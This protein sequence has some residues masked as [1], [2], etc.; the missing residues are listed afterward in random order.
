VSTEDFIELLFT[1]TSTG[2]EAEVTDSTAIV[3]SKPV[4]AAEVTVKAEKGETVAL[5]IQGTKVQKSDISVEGK[6]SMDLTVTTGQFKKN[7]VSGG[8]KADS[9]SFGSGAK[10]NKSTFELGKGKDSITFGAQ[11]KFQGKT[12]IDLGK[13]AKDSVEFKTAPTKG[14]VEFD[15][16]DSRDEFTIAG[17]TYNG[18]EVAENFSNIKINFAE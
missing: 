7:T 15:N 12:T 5:G 2:F 3:A 6:G 17:E 11:T 18:T 16:V 8:K 9:V 10:I 14:K 1:S 13:G 4:K